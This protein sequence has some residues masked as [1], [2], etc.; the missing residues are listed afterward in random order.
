MSLQ[1]RQRE[2]AQRPSR[3]RDAVGRMGTAVVSGIDGIEALAVRS[4]LAERSLVVMLDIIHE[5]DRELEA[6]Q[7]DPSA[8]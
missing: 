2:S 8:G 1:C 6:T 7:L 4:D 5:A 3:D